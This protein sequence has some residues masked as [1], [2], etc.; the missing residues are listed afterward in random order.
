MAR[1][2]ERGKYDYNFDA[3][4]QKFEESIYGTLKGEWRLKLLQEDLASLHK[5]RGLSVWDAGCGLG[6]MSAWFAKEGHHV[7]ANDLSF[8]M[9]ERA[10][11]NLQKEGCE[12]TLHQASAQ[13]MANAIPQQDVVLFHAVL[14][15]LAEPL[16]SLKEVAGRVK[17]D[18][19]LSLLFFNQHSLIY[20]NMLKGGWRVGMVRDGSWYGRG[21]KLTPPHPQTPEDVEALLKAEGFEIVTYTGIRVFHDYM[22]KEALSQTNMEELL[23]ME[24]RYCRKPTFRSMGRYIHFVAHKRIE[25]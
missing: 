15:W 22:E 19:V 10:K 25:R 9:L 5:Q 3:M 24:Y 6:Q 2:K 12:V 23:E 7:I 17:E 8:K 21:K 1:V 11:E 18:G 20:R 4:A 13:E 16:E 14:E